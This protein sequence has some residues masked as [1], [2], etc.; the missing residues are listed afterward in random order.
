MKEFLRDLGRWFDDPMTQALL[1]SAGALVVLSS[2]GRAH[3]RAEDA[4]RRLERVEHRLEL[5]H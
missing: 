2:L 5:G 4:E 1:A 3:A